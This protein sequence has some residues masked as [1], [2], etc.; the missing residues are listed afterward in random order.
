VSQPVPEERN[1]AAELKPGDTP[2]GEHTGELTGEGDG[3][4]A[5]SAQQEENAETSLDQPSS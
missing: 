5:A 2:P 4:D 3:A 1:D